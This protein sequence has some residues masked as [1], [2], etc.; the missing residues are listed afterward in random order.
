MV[1]RGATYERRDADL[2]P[3]PSWV[4]DALCE[5]FPVDGLC[6]WEP[7]CGEGD[8]ARALQ[9]NGAAIIATDANVFGYAGQILQHDFT[10]G[11]PAD[12]FFAH[13]K[14]DMLVTNPPYGLRSK[15]AESFVE[16][17][18]E[19]IEAGRITS[20]AMLLPVDFDSAKGRV[21]LFRDCRHFAAKVVLIRRI[22]WF[23][24]PN[25]KS[26]PS[27]SHAWFVWSRS[28]AAGAPA[29]VLYAPTEPKE[30]AA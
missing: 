30:T 8:M 1:A 18:I 10:E 23:E 20:A 13:A 22:K 5:H 19:M 14:I 2:Y 26:S 29:R 24:D 7:A 21:R 12:P 3:T 6:C 17:S 4:T 25:C 16:R 15:L 27:A 9:A 11:W 28:D